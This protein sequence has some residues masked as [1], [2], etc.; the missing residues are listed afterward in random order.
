LIMKK[1]VNAWRYKEKMSVLENSFLYQE[2]KEPIDNVSQLA[3]NMHHVQIEDLLYANYMMCDYR[4]QEIKNILKQL[5][6]DNMQLMIIMHG[7]FYNKNAHWYDTPYESAIIPPELLQRWRCPQ[8]IAALTLPHKNPYIAQHTAPM[9]L[10]STQWS[11][12]TLLENTSGFRLWFAQDQKQQTPK[13]VIYLSIASVEATNCVRNIVLLR[14][15]I[16]L[17]IDL[18]NDDTYPAKMAGINH[19]IYEHQSGLTLKIFGFT[20]KLPLLLNLI[21]NKIKQ[22]SYRQERF[23][24]IKNQII[25]NWEN[26]IKERPIL[27]LYNQ[28]TGI[29]QP[30]HPPYLS[31]LN[32]IKS[33][34]LSDI[35]PFIRQVQQ[36]NSLEVFIYGNWDQYQARSF[37]EKIKYTLRHTGQVHQERQ[38]PLLLLKNKGE[39]HYQCSCKQSDSA[40]IIYYQCPIINP[41]N[42]ALYLLASQLI[43]APFYADLRTEKQLGYMLG[44]QNITLNQRPGLVFFIQSPVTAPKNLV[45]AIDTFIT[46]LP[47]LLKKI[48]AEELEETKK[49]LISQILT[50][51]PKMMRRAQYFWS[52]IRVKDWDFNRDNNIVSA[53][54]KLTSEHIIDFV[55]AHIITQKQQRLILTSPS[56]K[57]T[58]ENY[59]HTDHNFTS[60]SATQNFLKN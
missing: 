3:T 27:Q 38:P 26:S 7:G 46:H 49:G 40:V 2:A 10:T 34:Q 6:P 48:T 31:Q 24:I 9:K 19:H 22:S 52:A 18:I 13:G 11:T 42:I 44:C 8:S 59:Y 30:Q 29:I 56:K 58:S 39:I 23:D 60:I 45:K 35:G 25:R 20:T 47:S 36:N 43:S 41:T 37:A 53:I 1:G 21:L 4:P 32:A 55:M 15:V 12:P 5:T 28:L 16:A 51:E 14:L 50:Q 54:K 57:D 17:F 33:I